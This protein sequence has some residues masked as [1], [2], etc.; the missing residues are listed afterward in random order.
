M[1]TYK[2]M[3]GSS[4]ACV[5]GWNMS[6]SPDIFNSNNLQAS[7][8]RKLYWHIVEIRVAASSSSNLT[9]YISFPVFK[10][11]QIKEYINEKIN[12]ILW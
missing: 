5:P 7:F 11:K 12:K 9:I 6:T 2:D 10:Q 4:C 3:Q 8:H 1:S